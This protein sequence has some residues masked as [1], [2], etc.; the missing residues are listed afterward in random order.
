MKTKIL[1]GTPSATHINLAMDEVQ[2]LTKIGYKCDTFIYTR[3]KPLESKLIKLIGVIK[4]SF[5]LIRLLYQLKPDILYLNSRFGLMG[6][7]RDF[8]TTVFIR[9]FYWNKLNIA[10]KTHGSDFSF[11]FKKSFFFNSIIIPYLSKHVMLWFFLSNEEKTK[12]AELAP[13][14]AQKAYVTGNIIDPARSVKSDSFMAQQGLNDN[15]FKFFFAGRMI[16][17]KGIFSI[18]RA[19]PNFKYKDESVFILAGNGEEYD[20]V[21]KEIKQLQIEKY[22]HL[23]G[24]V[25]EEECDHF[26]AN[27]DVLVFPTYFDEG[28]PMALF[29]SVGAGLPIITTKTRAAIDH[30]NEPDNCLWVDG[31][32]SNTVVKA[33]NKIYE[34]EDL[35]KKMMKNNLILGEKF[36]Q[37]KITQQMHS[38][39]ISA[40]A[41]SN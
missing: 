7:T 20:E 15:R 36:S 3:N 25:A 17:E 13:E 23:T 31:K 16:A 41:F 34:D 21:K 22:V 6:T 5:K 35:R 37:E 14:I 10:I 33:L 11:L 9:L 26:F 38:D 29:K 8:I 27:T 12:I 4:N 18:I 32:D 1:V 39:F 28:F 30:L 19:I 2:G 24:F 40:N